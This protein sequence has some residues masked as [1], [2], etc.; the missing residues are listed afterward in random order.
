MIVKPGFKLRLHIQIS[1]VIV[2]EGTEDLIF[3]RWGWAGG[4]RGFQGKQVG[5]SRRY[6]SI[7]GELSTFFHW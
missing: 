7:K 3:L 6:Q 1:L 5:I 4:S 2:W